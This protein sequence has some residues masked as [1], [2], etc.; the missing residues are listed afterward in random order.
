MNAGPSQELTRD[1]LALC[2]T[3]EIAREFRVVSESLGMNVPA[4]VVESRAWELTFSRLQLGKPTA[5]LLSGGPPSPAELVQAA[6]V[7]RGAGAAIAVGILGEALTDLAIVELAGDLGLTAV[8]EVRPLAAVIALLAAGARRPW[9][10]SLRRLGDPDRRRLDGVCVG[11]RGGGAFVPMGGLL[12]GF[13][14]EVGGPVPIGEAR[15][16]ATAV[17]AMHAADVVPS[18][19]ARPELQV[20]EHA[21]TDTLF[22]PARALSD[23]A[24]KRLLET[25]GL[26]VPL[27][28]LCTSPS[29]A[30]AEAARL[31][32]PVRV[33]LASPDLRL[34]DH[35]D[36]SV[37][38]VESASKVR[39]VY[40]QLHTLAKSRMKSARILGAG[41]S[42]SPTASALLRLYV[43]PLDHGKMLV[44]LGFADPHGV[45]SGDRT[46]TVF[47]ASGVTLERCVSRLAG[48]P[49]VLHGTASQRR[50]T[51]GALRSF[52]LRL[53]AFVDDQRETVSAVE[54]DPVALL[55]DGSL[56]IREAC[57]TVSDFFERSLEA[58]A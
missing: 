17:T 57:V 50:A 24:S 29:R 56:E 58:P 23:P 47:P 16:C 28:E 39:E 51:V 43:S 6:E 37:P 44:E 41:V 2:D 10:A 32:F 12:L 9:R 26:P 15:D 42:V 48:A 36:L 54:L 1:W 19:P 11:E 52:L 5:L 18:P 40:R 25:Y 22:G 8:D 27:E 49:L 4:E 45:A 46:H 53:G 55:I 38:A 14:A 21:V 7:A 20:D 33:S 35:P 30:A 3:P 31:G 34:W 13:E